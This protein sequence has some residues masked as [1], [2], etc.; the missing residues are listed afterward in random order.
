MDLGLKNKNAA[1]TGAS[2]GI[3]EAIA[4]SLA[5]EGC[6]IA[7]CARNQERM[8]QTI[9]ELQAKGVKAVG[10]I[11]DLSSEA[12]CQHF[13]EEAVKQLGSLQILVNNVG[14]MIP[15]TLATMAEEAWST[16][17]NVNLMAAI[18]ST[19]H[20]VE[21]LKKNEWARILNI[22]GYSGTQLMPGALSTTIPNAGL[23]GFNKLMANELGS[24]NIT[25]NNICPGMVNTE[26]WGPRGELMAKIR[27]TTPEDL[28]NGFSAQTM[29]GRWAEPSEVGD[30]AAF[31][32][33]EKNSYMT[34][35]TVEVCGGITKYIS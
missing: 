22:T 11:A 29:L 8:D 4:H 27:N 25:V 14:G 24:H 10:V 6:N 12:G 17:I 32:V 35:T 31:L 3:G 30:L 21:H 26:S 7:I 28:R 5:N 16:A 15:G 9:A 19:K 18:F 2:Q 20:S 1:I 34:G 23:I 13:I 33:S